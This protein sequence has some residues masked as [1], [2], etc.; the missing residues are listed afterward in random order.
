MFLKKKAV[1][2]SV[3]SVVEEAKKE[4]KFSEV[5]KVRRFSTENITQEAIEELYFDGVPPE[6]IMGFVSPFVKFG[7]AADLIRRYLD[8]NTKLVLNTT[9]G[10][11]H[12][13]KNLRGSVYIDASV[14]RNVIVLQSFSK[15]LI[16]NI[17][18]KVLPLFCDDIKAK[19]YRPVNEKVSQLVDALK[20]VKVNFK[21]RYDNSI[22]II[23]FDGYSNSE[24]FF[25]EALYRAEI[26]PCA[27][28]GG[29]VGTDLSLDNPHTF[30]YANDRVWE[31]QAVIVFL[32]FRKGYRHSVFKTENFEKTNKSFAILRAHLA[33]RTVESIY[34]YDQKQAVN[35]VDALCDYF[36]CTP[37]LLMDFM[38]QY[39]F[40]VTLGGEI[41]L[42]SV[43][44]IDINKKTVSFF[45]DV[46]KGDILWLVKS[47]DF[48]ETTKK[49]FLTFIAD[50][51]AYGEVEG[52]V[53]FDCILRRLYNESALKE[54]NFFSICPIAGFSTFGELYGININ[55]T[56]TA[57]FFFRE[58]EGTEW[59]ETDTFIHDYSNFK[60]FVD[61][62]IKNQ[63]TQ[64]N[65]IR[66]DMLYLLNARMGEV[67]KSIANFN[68]VV[69]LSITITDDVT[70]AYD[71]MNIFF[72]KLNEVHK[73]LGTLM[74]RSS[75][76]DKATDTLKTILTVIDELADQTNM[77]ALNAA[78][79]AAR[80][81]HAGRGFAVVADEVKQLADGTQKQ[82]KNSIDEVNSITSTIRGRTMAIRTLGG[83]VTE[84][85]Q[86]GK[87]FGKLVLA[88]R[89]DSMK[90]QENS[91]GLTEFSEAVTHLIEEVR[92]IH[93]LELIVEEE[94]DLG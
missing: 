59:D 60:T 39:T 9:A 57:L 61:I 32:K 52:A 30:I 53:F 11:L 91:A 50:R 65:K 51:S 7:D 76:V 35:I 12:A 23:L 73:N 36:K 49:S 41:Y 56:L 87:P 88:V 34:D 66:T 72:T 94:E 55:Q 80:A 62:R 40:A 77:L 79:E 85:V 69:E 25:M 46:G 18:I 21:M 92:R 37:E 38:S 44:N 84:M 48:I 82:L 45:C 90:F 93:D 31:N 42:R 13:D 15:E 33:S 6:L 74:S 68:Q 71:Q 19:Q 29:S 20:D 64:T 8:P 81:G 89:D 58:K 3:R 43:A 26:F 47:L 14:G 4:E 5:I 17:D 54:A 70:K 78:I 10:E 75:N 27:L 83:N 86:I 2:E 22:G 24:N 63:L 16:E 28:I 67:D 1:K